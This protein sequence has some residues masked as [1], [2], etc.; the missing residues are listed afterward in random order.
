MFEKSALNCCKIKRR[1]KKEKTTTSTIVATI[2]EINFE[3][4]KLIE[5]IDEKKMLFGENHNDE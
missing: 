4:C 3:T 1:R 2:I 5:K